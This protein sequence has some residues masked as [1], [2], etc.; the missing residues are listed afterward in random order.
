MGLQTESARRRRAEAK[1][2][3]EPALIL[4]ALET[5][6]S[7]ALEYKSGGCGVLDIIK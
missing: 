7:A 2:D 6:L 3:G 4:G 5:M 1:L